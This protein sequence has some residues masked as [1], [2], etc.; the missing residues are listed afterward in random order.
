MEYLES[1]IGSHMHQV[2]NICNYQNLIGYTQCI[3]ELCFIF[4]RKGIDIISAFCDK[5]IPNRVSTPVVVNE[6]SD[7]LNSQDN[8]DNG[9]RV[10]IFDSV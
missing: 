5:A 4:S 1:P 2:S 7:T 6:T 3:A 8:I 9:F 10:S